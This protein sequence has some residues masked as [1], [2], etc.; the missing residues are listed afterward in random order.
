MCWP[1]QH[2][3]R[4][5]LCNV[6]KRCECNGSNVARIDITCVR[7]NQGFGPDAIVALAEHDFSLCQSRGVM[8]TMMYAATTVLSGLFLW[9][10]LGL[11]IPDDV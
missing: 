1:D 7:R 11:L 6:P 4:D 2:N 8:M 10:V 3:A 5:C 9:G